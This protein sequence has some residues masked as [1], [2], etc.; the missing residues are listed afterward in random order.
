MWHLISKYFNYIFICI[1]ESKWNVIQVTWQGVLYTA[2]YLKAPGYF[3]LLSLRVRHNSS[4]LYCG[5]GVQM[6]WALSWEIYLDLLQRK[7]ALLF[8]QMLYNLALRTG[9]L[10]SMQ[11]KRGCIFLLNIDVGICKTVTICAPP[12][13]WPRIKVIF[14]L[15]GWGCRWLDRIFSSTSQ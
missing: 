10:T 7:S 8:A 6:L 4:I 5:P 14:I 15:S 3:M 9:R 1:T 2:V 13:Q 11:L 12:L